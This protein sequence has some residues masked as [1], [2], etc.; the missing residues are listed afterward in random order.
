MRKVKL[1][2][3]GDVS[4]HATNN[5]PN[6][7]MPEPVRIPSSLHA[8][9][10]PDN[11]WLYRMLNGTLFGAVARWDPPGKRKEIRPI[12]WNGRDFISS[13]FGDH[14]PLYNS[15]QLSKSS[16]APVL[17]VEGEKSADA[18]TGYVPHDWVVVTWQGGAHAWRHT[19]WSLLVGHPCVIWPDNDAPGINAASGI[20][21]HLTSIG[22]SVGIVE[23]PDAPEGWDLADELPNDFTTQHIL[24]L[25]EQALTATRKPKSLGQL[26]PLEWADQISPVL[27]RRWLV[28]DLLATT[29]LSIVFGHPS[30]GKSFLALDLACHVALGWPW[31]GLKVEQGL[32]IYIAAEGA[33]GLRNRLA[34]FMALHKVSDMMLAIIPTPINLQD[35]NADTDRLIA[36]IEEAARQSGLKLALVVIDTLAKTFGAGKENTDDMSPYVANC[37]RVSSHFGCCV[38]IVHHRPKDSDSREP[39]GHSSLKAGVDT[40]ILVEAGDP[41]I[42]TVLKQKDGE[43]GAK[44]A[45]R[46]QQVELGLDDDGEAVTSCVVETLPSEWIAACAGKIGNLKLTEIQTSVLYELRQSLKVNGIPIPEDIPDNLINRRMLAKVVPITTLID[47]YMISSA[48]GAD[49]SDKNRDKNCKR[50]RRTLDKL[51]TKEKVGIWQGYVWEN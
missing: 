30:A 26:L 20:K 49:T 12:I 4:K 28:R 11:L 25:L 24:D 27:S 45:F 29:G 50:V 5:V 38:L 33:A 7:P 35:P 17:I 36:T 47:N 1:S 31:N 18:A 9:G 6:L 44:F 43:D 39:R 23:L 46:L 2:E 16:L 10:A 40:V 37:E 32:V 14:R 21:D 41:K 42:A 13:G 48:S 51:K 34:A 8:L 15:D 3:E 22:I 19:D